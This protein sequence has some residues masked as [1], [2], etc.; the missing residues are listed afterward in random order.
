MAEVKKYLKIR[1]N[2]YMKKAGINKVGISKKGFV[3]VS[4]KR[5][6][7]FLMF[8]FILSSFVNAKDRT[9]NIKPWVGYTNVSMKDVNASLSETMT[10]EK[11]LDNYS[12]TFYYADEVDV[13][14][15]DMTKK[16]STSKI[17]KASIVGVD[18]TK[19]YDKIN[20]GVRIE[21][22][23][24]NDGTRSNS[25]KYS[26]DSNEEP[27]DMFENKLKISDVKLVPIMVGG[28]YSKPLNEK[29]GVDASCYIGFGFASARVSNE[30]IVRKIDEDGYLL[31]PKTYS[32]DEDFSGMGL[33]AD[34]AV[35][36]QYNFSEVVS[37][38]T[39]LG[40]RFAKI[41]EMKDSAGDY[42]V[43]DDGKKL[44]FDFSGMLL[45]LGLNFKF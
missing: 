43:K 45:T 34:L 4:V 16:N 27:L 12:Y 29:W 33:V 40:Y 1:R 32:Y 44:P 18:I 42:L 14:D 11:Y 2:V 41:N 22:L 9:W 8:V 23:T 15:N 24:T 37:L 39:S 26:Y 28:N 17:N 20:A 3:K 6:L 5:V 30:T 7:S 10:T 35:G 19:N 21:Y 13:I 36:G 31:L 25:L 38:A